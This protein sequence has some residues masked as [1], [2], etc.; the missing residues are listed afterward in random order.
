MGGEQTKGQYCIALEVEEMAEVGG[1]RCG[2][3][4]PWEIFGEKEEHLGDIYEAL[5]MVLDEIHNP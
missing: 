4:M 2:Q 3:D 1:E 5:V